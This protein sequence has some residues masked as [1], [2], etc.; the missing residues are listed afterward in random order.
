MAIITLIFFDEILDLQYFLLTLVSAACFF[1]QAYS[2]RYIPAVAW[3]FGVM[4]MGLCWRFLDFSPDT[5]IGFYWIY[6]VPIFGLTVVS[7]KQGV[8]FI[9]LI[10]IILIAKIIVFE[11]GLL[12]DQYVDGQ[13]RD[14]IEFVISV[15][16]VSACLFLLENIRSNTQAR[17][18]ETTKTLNSFAYKDPLTGKYNRHA[19]SAHFQS[20]Q[21]F[22]AGL[23]FALMD[24]D[25][26]KNVNDNYGHDVGDAVLC[27]VAGQINKHIPNNAYLYRWGGEEF[28]LVFKSSNKADC[29]NICETIRQ[30][31]QRTP[32]YIDGKNEIFVTLSIG[33]S[34]G[35]EGKFIGDCL[36]EADNNLYTAK[37][38]GR[39]CVV[40]SA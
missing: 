19:F 7:K 16:I 24:I 22:S 28:L 34:C 31:C 5:V 29:D 38:S 27:H 32:Y 15:T 4:A 25:F 14:S 3:M 10:I 30:A 1:L 11:K 8:L 26:F 39:N 6:L 33:T 18:V 2:K 40:T 36:K 21:S 13:L 12:P 23:Y 9:A 20:E 35:A 37:N 17:L